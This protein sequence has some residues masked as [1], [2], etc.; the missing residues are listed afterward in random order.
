MFGCAQFGRTLPRAITP[1]LAAFFVASLFSAFSSYW[2]A[3]LILFL[4][5]GS[6]EQIIGKAGRVLI[7]GTIIAVA[8]KGIKAGFTVAL[9]GAVALSLAGVVAVTPEA[10]GVAF[11]DM[12]QAHPKITTESIK[13]FERKG[14]DVLVNLD[15]PKEVDKGAAEA[16]FHSSLR[17]QILLLQQEKKM[18]MD[19]KQDF[20]E[21]AMAALT[22]GTS[23][24]S[25][26][27]A[28][29]EELRHLGELHYLPS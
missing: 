6:R 26:Q 16:T 21:L 14:D 12:M 4:Y 17:E 1:S 8:W 27:G 15:V 9:A 28:G 29:R 3:V 18:L 20:K 22:S 11:Q 13:G 19:H 5:S 25:L 23:V 2:N 10:F 24:N 7:L